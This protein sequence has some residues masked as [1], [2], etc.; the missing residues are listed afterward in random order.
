ML[1][2]QAGQLDA[3][4]E[5]IRRAIAI[6]PSSAVYFSNFGNIL[7]DIGRV[8]EAIAAYQQAIRLKPDYANA[9]YN[10]GIA[11]KTK[12]AMTRQ[13]MPTGGPSN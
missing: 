3:A 8:D 9:H 13:S 7:K 10:L 12:G 5:L 4:V 6:C 1:H 2:A 11:L